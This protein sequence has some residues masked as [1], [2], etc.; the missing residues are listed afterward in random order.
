MS[1]ITRIYIPIWFDLNVMSEPRQI[2]IAQIYIP[3]WFDLKDKDGVSYDAVSQIYIPVWFDLNLN[4]DKLGVKMPQFTF[5][6]GS[7]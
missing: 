3:V 7:I 4:A 6:Y 5:Q 2:P 1:P